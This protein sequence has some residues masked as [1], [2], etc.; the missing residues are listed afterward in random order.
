MAKTFVQC[1]LIDYERRDLGLGKPLGR[2]CYKISKYNPD[3]TER[4]REEISADRI[5]MKMEQ[6]AKNAKYLET[7]GKVK[8][9]T[10]NLVNMKSAINLQPPKT[11]IDIQHGGLN[12][13]LDAGTGNTCAIFGSSKRGKSTIM[14]QIFRDYYMNKVPNE[15][16]A[17][18]FARNPQ[19]STYKLPQD[20]LILCDEFRPDIVMDQCEVNKLS[21]NKFAFLNLIDDFIN[22]KHSLSLDDLILTMRNSNMSTVICLQY[23]NTLSKPARSNVNNVL[24]FGQNTDEAAEV[25]INVYLRTWFKKNGISSL[26]DQITE[27]HRLTSDHGFFH[28]HPATGTV[29]L[30][31]LIQ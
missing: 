7:T 14:M 9:G 3:G 21:G 27:F 31:K 15:L 17:I 26:M 22:L 8:P 18:L 16:I 19:I 2:T 20:K 1:N 13:I 23:V 25:C 30:C 10:V 12:L 11:T 24:L 28:V 29:S 5:K 6:Q 4:S